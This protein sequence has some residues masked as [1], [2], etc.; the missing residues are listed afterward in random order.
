MSEK[1]F[2][3]HKN[4]LENSPSCKKKK[5]CDHYKI[6]PAPPSPRVKANDSLT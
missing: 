1:D 2:L 6:F 4:M 3:R 5:K